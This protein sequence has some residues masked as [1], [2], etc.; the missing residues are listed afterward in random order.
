MRRRYRQDPLTGELIEISRSGAS[1][2]E[3][4]SPGH[5]I[6]GSFD[7]YVSPI[8]GS[9]IRTQRDLDNH[10]KK[11]NVVLQAEFGDGYFEKKA[12]ERV[13]FFQ[14]KVGR[15]EQLERRRMFYE[16]LTRAERC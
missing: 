4:G 11:H 6:K 1:V 12:Q 5:I 10:N 2:A 14:A 13:N 16:I 8:D 7:P 9:I 3:T 15:K